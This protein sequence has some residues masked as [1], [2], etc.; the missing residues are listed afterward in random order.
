MRTFIRNYVPGGT[1]F[2]TVVTYDRRPFLTDALARACLHRAIQATRDK[3][4]FEVIAISLLPEH[5][6]TVWALP[7]HDC[8][9]SIRM[10]KVKEAF[11]KGYLSGGGR[12]GTPT[13]SQ[14]ASGRRAVWQPRFWE[15]TVRDQAD[16]KRCVDYVHWNPAKHG[17]VTRVADYPWSTYLRYV[18][19]G[20]YAG[21]WGQED[22]C[23]GFNMPE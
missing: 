21:D 22:P 3:W 5:F 11:T 17:L 10:Q 18:R 23:P 14:A 15:H 20:E 6:H 1:F 2:F 12:E 8:D 16:L 13:P 19:L 4:P 7:Y 9:F